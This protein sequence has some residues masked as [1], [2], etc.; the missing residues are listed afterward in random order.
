MFF[1]DLDNLLICE[2]SKN[3]AFLDPGV[4]DCLVFPDPL[5]PSFVQQGQVQNGHNAQSLQ[6]PVCL[7]DFRSAAL[8]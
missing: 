1:L 7:E 8:P 4:L 6:V 2:L 3:L 5:Q